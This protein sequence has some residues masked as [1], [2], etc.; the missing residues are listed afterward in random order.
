MYSVTVCA[1]NWYSHLPERVAVQESVE[2]FV[3]CWSYTVRTCLALRPT[4]KL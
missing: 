4:M 3:T 1:Q 2:Q